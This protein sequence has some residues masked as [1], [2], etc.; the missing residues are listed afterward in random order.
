MILFDTIRNR[1]SKITDIR[2]VDVR[3][4]DKWIK[5]YPNC[6]PKYVL[7]NKHKITFNTNK[8]RYE[9]WKS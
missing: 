9:L 7:N 3:Y 6:F 8:L 4:L 1:L 5:E 2:F